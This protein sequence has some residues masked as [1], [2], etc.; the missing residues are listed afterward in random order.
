LSL[1]LRGGK[2]GG[3]PGA[4]LEFQGLPATTAA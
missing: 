3:K 4:L 1:D 2:H